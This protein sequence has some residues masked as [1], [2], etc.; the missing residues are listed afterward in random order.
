[1]LDLKML[2]TGNVSPFTI[3]GLLQFM[4]IAQSVIALWSLWTVSHGVPSVACYQN[5]GSQGLQ[6]TRGHEGYVE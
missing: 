2:Q 1:M 6:S 3:L 5:R 4:L